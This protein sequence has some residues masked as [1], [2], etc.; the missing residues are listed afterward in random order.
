M[1]RLAVSRAILVERFKA[2]MGLCAAMAFEVEGMQEFLGALGLRIGE[3]LLGIRGAVC[4]LP[5]G[6][7]N[8]P[9]GDGTRELH[10]MRDDEHRL[11]G[12]GQ[13]DDH[14]EHFMHHL[15][16]ECGGDLVEQQNLGVQNQR[17]ADRHTL[18]LATGKLMRLGLRAVGEM[19]AIEQFHRLLSTSAF[20][21]FCTSIGAMVMLPSTSLFGNSS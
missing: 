2:L 4:D 15:G 17:A 3:E 18:A 16:V 13:F 8:H 12:I 6:E 1:C 21:R 9:V 5:V 20:F 19:H 10:L 7:Q 14:L 11:P